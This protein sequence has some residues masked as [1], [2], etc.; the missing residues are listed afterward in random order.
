M[1]G[2]RSRAPRLGSRHAVPPVVRWRAG[3]RHGRSAVNL[4]TP[5]SAF[6]KYVAGRGADLCGRDVRARSPT[7]VRQEQREQQHRVLANAQRESEAAIATLEPWRSALRNRRTAAQ[8]CRGENR[9][10]QTART[11]HGH[12][13]SRS[14]PAATPPPP[15]GWAAT[16]ETLGLG[17]CVTRR[18]GALTVL[19]HL[20]RQTVQ[21]VGD[22]PWQGSS[23][24]WQGSSV[25]PRHCLGSSHGPWVHPV[26]TVRHVRDKKHPPWYR[27]PSSVAMFGSCSL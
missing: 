8:P 25:P 11:S 27:R 15:C 9:V 5:P 26:R 21:V 18:C 2:L 12:H 1:C 16:G 19:E 23:V 7:R 3:C 17:Q 14:T 20:P 24:P 4:R 22:P 13:G 6:Y 10:P